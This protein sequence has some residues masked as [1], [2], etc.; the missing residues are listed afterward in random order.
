MNIEYKTRVRYYFTG[1]ALSFTDN[2]IRTLA[3]RKQFLRDLWN[4]TDVQNTITK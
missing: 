1:Q 4:H 2:L 3:T